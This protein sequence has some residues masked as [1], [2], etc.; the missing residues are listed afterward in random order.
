LQPGQYFIEVQN[1]IMNSAG[2]TVN[3]QVTTTLTPG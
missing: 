2:A 3:I 1:S